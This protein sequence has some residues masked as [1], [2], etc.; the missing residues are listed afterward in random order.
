MLCFVYAVS[1]CLTQNPQ[2]FKGH[3]FLSHAESAE[4]EGIFREHELHMN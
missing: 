1:A 4:L 3:G 2:K